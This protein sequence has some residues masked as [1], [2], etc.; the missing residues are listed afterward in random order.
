MIRPVAIVHYER[1]YWAAFILDSVVTAMTW[2]QRQALVTD[3][4]VLAT[5]TWILPTFQAIGVAV[6]V[7]LWYFTARA[8]SVVAKWAVV[9]LATLS[10]VSAVQTLASLANGSASLGIVSI[11]SL[12]ANAL[13]LAAAVYLFKPA[14]RAWFAEGYDADLDT[15]AHA[16]TG[17]HTDADRD[18]FA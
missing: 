16:D 1:L 14:S 15:D 12:I 7:L 9:V 5:A 4:P 3:N 18:N 17:S 11:L 6:T 8:P 10:T 13:Y 2:A